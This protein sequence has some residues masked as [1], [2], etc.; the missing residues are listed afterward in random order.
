[1]SFLTR[2][3]LWKLLALV[4]AFGVWLNVSNEPDLATIVSVPVEYNHFPKDL[5][6]SSEIV[7]TI[8]L[9]AR[10]PSGLLRGLHDSRIAAI[11]DFASVKAPGE[12]TFTVTPA[13]LKL[14]RGVDLIRTIP[15]QLRFKFEKRATRSVSVDV[16]FSGKLPPGL[17]IVG[18]DITPQQLQIAGPEGHVLRSG[19]LASDPF[20]LT[21]VR[22]DSAQTLSVYAAEPEVRIL[23]TPQVRVKIR[24]RPMETNR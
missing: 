4:A 1:M 22:G 18:V 6:I 14:P 3:L 7:E 17:S 11:I 10:G 16:P 8:D 24:V 9:E 5:E 12:R 19:K 13:E 15:A 2:N 20:D 21:N 23:N